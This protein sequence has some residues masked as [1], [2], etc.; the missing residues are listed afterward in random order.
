MIKAEVYNGRRPVTATLVTFWV[1]TSSVTTSALFAIHLTLTPVF[2]TR[3]YF[4]TSKLDH[5]QHHI[6]D[7]GFTAEICGTETR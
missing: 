2:G 4:T 6:H 1:N 3:F 7:R 5:G